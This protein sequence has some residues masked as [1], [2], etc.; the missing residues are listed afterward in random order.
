[1]LPL[2]KGGVSKNLF[3]YLKTTTNTCRES[4]S[5][6]GLFFPACPECEGLTALNLGRF[7]GL[8]LQRAPLRDEV[9]SPIGGDQAYLLLTVKVVDSLNS[10]FLCKSTACVA[11]VWAPLCHLVGLGGNRMLILLAVL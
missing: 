5:S 7:S 11:S 8:C 3:R 4:E 2:L 9:T 10:V 6:M 1:M